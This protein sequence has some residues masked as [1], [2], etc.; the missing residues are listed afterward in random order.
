MLLPAIAV[1]A[2]SIVLGLV[3]AYAYTQTPESRTGRLSA[4]WIVAFLVLLVLFLGSA[5]S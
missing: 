4:F 2:A 5:W 3:M 1:Q